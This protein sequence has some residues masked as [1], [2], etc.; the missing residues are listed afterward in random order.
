MRY[1]IE[2]ICTKYVEGYC[3]LSFPRKFGDNMAKK[4]MD[5]ATKTEID[6]VKTASRRELK[7][8]QKLQDFYLEIKQLIQRLQQV[9]QKV[10]K[11]KMKQI[12][13]KKFTCHQKKDSKQ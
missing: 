5:T 13:D 4:I 1:S 8:L 6:A 10:N 12:K 3:F 7:K 2:L 9:K 11:K